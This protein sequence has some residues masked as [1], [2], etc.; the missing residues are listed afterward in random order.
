MIAVQKLVVTSEKR[1]SFE[2]TS[3]RVKKANGIVYKALRENQRKQDD[4][5]QYAALFRV[6]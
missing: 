3:E 1:Y 5:L 4:S 6:K 2:N